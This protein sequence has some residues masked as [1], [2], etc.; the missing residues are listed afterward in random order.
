M[1]I[2]QKF[3]G[4]IQVALLNVRFP[5]GAK[6]IFTAALRQCVIIEHHLLH[7]NEMKLI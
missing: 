1:L 2:E 7:A 3:I 5:K 4:H 6:L